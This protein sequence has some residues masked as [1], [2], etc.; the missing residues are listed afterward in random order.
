MSIALKIRGLD[1]EEIGRA[2]GGNVVTCGC[3]K[4]LLASSVATDSREVTPG[5]L[6]CAIPGERVDGHDYISAAVSAGATAVLCERI[7]EEAKRLSFTAVVV[8]DTVRAMNLLSGY[9]RDLLSIKVIGIT[10]SVGKTTT[11]EMIAAVCGARFRT[12][13][14]VGNLNSTVGMPLSLFSLEPDTEVAVLEMGMNHFGEIETMSL[15]ARPDIAVITNIGTAHL[16][17]LGS[18]EGI[19]DA[20]MEITAGMDP[21]RSVLLLNGDEPLLLELRN[22]VYHPLYFSAGSCGDWHAANVREDSEGLLLDC[23]ARS[24][25]WHDIRVPARGLHQVNN[26]LA[27]IA[28]GQM[29]GMNPEEIREGLLKYQSAPMRQSLRNAGPMT[30]FEDCYNANPE[31]TRAAIDVLMT[32]SAEKKGRA[33]A[34]LGDMLE[35]GESSEDLHRR[36]GRYAAAKGIRRLICFGPLAG[37][38]AC[39]ATEGGMDPASVVSVADL[40]APEAAAEQILAWAEPGDV[41]LFKAS[42]GVAAERV[43]KL[44]AAKWENLC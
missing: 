8:P 1:A 3:P 5:S 38:I 11:K 10:G 6:F 33:C 29:L 42:R 12:H 34:L 14:T 39:G 31:S 23:V 37:A 7:P 16:E 9:Y 35:L 21:S 30:V 28:V 24:N 40:S 32:V 27:A 2:T 36:I 15:G 41:W 20:K 26:A 13:K 18:R 25:V 4:D 22:S 19:R 43:A 44:C 17:Y